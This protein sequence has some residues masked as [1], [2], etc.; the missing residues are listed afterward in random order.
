MSRPTFADLVSLEPQLA[1]LLAE[2]ESYHEKAGQHFCANVV[3]YGYRGH[4]PGLKLLLNDLVGFYSGKTGLLA[5]SEAYDMAYQT[6]YHA[7]PDCRHDGEC[8]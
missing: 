8:G 5:T 3:W 2:A 6:I 7:L 1:A 4:A